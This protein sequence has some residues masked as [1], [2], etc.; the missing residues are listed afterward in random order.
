MNGISFYFIEK[1]AISISSKP[2]WWEFKNEYTT[3]TFQQIMFVWL[4]FKLKSFDKI[5]NSRISVRSNNK[6]LEK[7]WTCV[8]ACVKLSLKWDISEFVTLTIIK[9]RYK[10]KKRNKKSIPSLKYVFLEIEA[11]ASYNYAMGVTR[12]LSFRY[13]EIHLQ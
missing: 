6:V 5:L 3:N 13:W 4:R 10:P 1:K 9:P 11:R 7:C 12:P 2:N 8:N